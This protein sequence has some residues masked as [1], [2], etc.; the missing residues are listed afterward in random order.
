MKHD[1]RD[2]EKANELLAQGSKINQ[3]LLAL[4]NVISALTQ[5]T[6]IR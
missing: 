6:M 1:F 5:V 3:S 4:G 2:Q